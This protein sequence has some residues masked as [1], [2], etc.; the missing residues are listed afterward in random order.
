MN[1]IR[2]TISDSSAIAGEIKAKYSNCNAIECF[3]EL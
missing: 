1:E 2:K 3:K